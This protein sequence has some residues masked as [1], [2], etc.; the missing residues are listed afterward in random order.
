MAR[1]ERSQAVMFPTDY[2]FGIVS[3]GCR[4]CGDDQGAGEYIDYLV[5]A[6][7]YEIVEKR[8]GVTFLTRPGGAAVVR[9]MIAATGGQ[10]T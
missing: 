1:E 9:E 3:Q 2:G 8:N 7:L 5:H 6:G 10:P 4:K